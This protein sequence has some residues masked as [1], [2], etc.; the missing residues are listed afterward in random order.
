MLLCF[1]AIFIL[2]THQSQLEEGLGTSQC[3]SN[4]KYSGLVQG[5]ST[6]SHYQ[7]WNHRL[8]ALVCC[9]FHSLLPKVLHS[10]ILHKFQKMNFE[11]RQNISKVLDNT[12]ENITEGFWNT[13]IGQMRVTPMKQ[14]NLRDEP[15]WTE[16]RWGLIWF[17]QACLPCQTLC[18]P[19]PAP[20]SAICHCC[21]TWKV[22]LDF[23]C[24]VIWVMLRELSQPKTAVTLR[25]TSVSLDFTSD[26]IFYLILLLVNAVEKNKTRNGRSMTLDE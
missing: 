9:S 16:K 8:A 23:L 18:S 15:S 24:K 10:T 7:N 11:K 3:H 26:N 6:S 13:Y 25:V 22:K 20:R 2:K 14:Q 5:Q 4:H 19:C 12:M 21:S 1:S 17:S